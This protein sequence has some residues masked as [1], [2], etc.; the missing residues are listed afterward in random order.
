MGFRGRPGQPE[1]EIDDETEEERE[2][3]GVEKEKN[4]IE[5]MSSEKSE[6][7]IAGVEEARPAENPVQAREFFGEV[8]VG[9]DGDEQQK[10]E[11]EDGWHDGRIKALS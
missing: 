7:E 5:G 1:E 3:C 9:S 4:R 6:T 8:E 2:Q 10:S 11:L